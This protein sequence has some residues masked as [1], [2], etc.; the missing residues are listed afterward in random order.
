[1]SFDKFTLS[2]GKTDGVA[3]GNQ[4]LRIA[5]DTLNRSVWKADGPTVVPH[6][7]SFT[8]LPAMIASDTMIV[9]T[10]NDGE[11]VYLAL[12]RKTGT[13]ENSMPVLQRINNVPMQFS[14]EQNYPNPFNGITNYE[15][16]IT[17]EEHVSIKV[18]D[19][20]GREIAVLVNEVLQP[21]MYRMRWDA[22]GFASGVYYYTMTVGEF[23]QTKSMILMK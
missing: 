21:G 2:Y 20:L 11:F 3:E 19:A 8:T 17:N 5:L 22:V 16:R 12:A 13:T 23:R 9:K 4:N 14:L 15:L 18:Y 10:L 6:T 1:M 7:T